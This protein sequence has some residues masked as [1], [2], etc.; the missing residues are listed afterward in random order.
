ML[1]QVGIKIVLV[2]GVCALVVGC[3]QSEGSNET[4]P[5]VQT[6][7]ETQPKNTKEAKAP[8]PASVPSASELATN[9]KAQS[10][11]LIEG[12]KAKKP[13]NEIINMAIA[14]TETGRQFLPGLI[15]KYPACKAYLEAV[16][17]VA[18]TMKDLPVE[19]IERDYHQDGKL[20]KMADGN[21]YHGKDLV[22]HPATVAA[23]AKNGIV[24][25]EQ[26]KS[27]ENEIAEVLAHLMALEH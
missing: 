10:K 9:Y 19:D 6:A 24:T 2:F 21:C 23:L 17:A 20:P 12:I 15:K 11:V 3:E 7:K 26:R 25:D 16:D 27:A 1:N 8:A 22:V 18:L 5:A 13:D 4:K 14:L